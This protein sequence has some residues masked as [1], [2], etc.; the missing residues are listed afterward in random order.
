MI[1]KKDMKHL[2]TPYTILLNTTPKSHL[3]AYAML[4][5]LPTTGVVFTLSRPADNLRQILNKQYTK[6]NIVFVDAISKRVGYNKSSTRDL[7]I[8]SP[9]DL[10]QISIALE[11]V[12]KALKGKDSFLIV[13]SLSKLTFYHKQNSLFQFMNVLVNQCRATNTKLVILGIEEDLPQN[14]R[15]NIEEMCDRVIQ[16]KG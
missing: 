9:E 11:K 6:A 16:M 14:L 5:Y 10:T 4:N 1:K 7:Y 3:K 8:D 2:P 12:L 15:D 13:D